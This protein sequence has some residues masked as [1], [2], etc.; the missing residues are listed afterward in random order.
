MNNKEIPA[1]R[2]KMKRGG[3]YMALLLRRLPTSETRSSCHHSCGYFT[4][5]GGHWAGM[6]PIVG[7]QGN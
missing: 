2:G 3:R 6:V 7:K 5:M 1:I 4:Q